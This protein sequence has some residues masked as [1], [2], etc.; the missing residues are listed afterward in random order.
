MTDKEYVISTFSDAYFL[1]GKHY[2]F[3]SYD[4]YL[5]KKRFATSYVDEE[6]AWKKAKYQIENEVLKKLSL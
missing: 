2:K 4:I 1:R 5:S 6:H 3:I